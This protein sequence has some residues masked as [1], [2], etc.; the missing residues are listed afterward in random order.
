MHSRNKIVFTILIVVFLAGLALACTATSPT[1]ASPAGPARGAMSGTPPP[2]KPASAPSTP[3]RAAPTPTLSVRAAISKVKFAGTIVAANQVSLAFATSGRLKELPVAEGTRVS[4]GTLLAA[5]DTTIL[6][7]QVAQAKAALD[8]ATANWKRVQSGPTSD[9]IALARSNLDRAKAAVDQAQAAYDR[10]GGAGNPFIQM[11]PQG[12]ALQQA[13]LAYQI[14]LAQYNQAVNRPTETE[15]EVS[16]A[17]LAQAQAAYDLAQQSLNNARIIAPFD[18]V[19]V[20]VTPKIGESVSA[21]TPVIVFAD[22]T[23][24]QVLAYVDETTLAN[25]RVDQPATISVDALGNQ[26]FTGRV[27]KIGLLATTTGNIVNVPVRIDIDK[28]NVPL[29]PGWSAIV[30]VTTRP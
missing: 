29:S 25:I 28:T 13:T 3:T 9:E 19:I 20:S 10:A 22:L 6:E 17:Q 21:F 5:L 11:M 16:K 8:L 23:Q 1:P 18:G 4:A 27:S 24:M 14:A 12:A 2:G 26:V 30:E 7:A 15:R